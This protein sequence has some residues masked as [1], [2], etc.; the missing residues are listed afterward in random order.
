MAIAILA[1]IEIKILF[2]FYKLVFAS[3]KTPEEIA[4]ELAKN[5][6]LPLWPMRLVALE[7]RVLS[8]LSQFL[9]S[10]LRRR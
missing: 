6:K 3:N 9:K 4:N 2:G 10:L 8:N 7:A 1:M 5:L